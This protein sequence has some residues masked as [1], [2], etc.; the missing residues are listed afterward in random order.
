V[1]FDDDFITTDAVVMFGPPR[2]STGSLNIG[3]VVYQLTSQQ[4]LV[5][6]VDQIN[7]EVIFATYGFTGTG[8]AVDGFEFL[9]LAVRMTP[10]LTLD[11]GQ[12]FGSIEIVWDVDP[13]ANLVLDGVMSNERTQQF[14]VEPLD[15]PT[16]PLAL[17]ILT[18]IGAAVARRV[19]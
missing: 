7:D 8:P 3:G 12:P 15:V 5:G 16:P 19:R 18:G 9:W 13:G 6:S 10:G 1:T 17:M 4:I 11:T 14:S 2:P